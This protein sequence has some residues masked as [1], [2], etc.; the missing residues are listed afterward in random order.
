MRDKPG[1]FAF[2]VERLINTDQLKLMIRNL[3]LTLT[4]VLISTM[5]SYAQQEVFDC[6]DAE[7]AALCDLADVNGYTFTNPDPSMANPP[8]GGLC[9]GG[10]FNNPGWFSFVAGSTD[11][12][13][14][15][16]P[17]PMTCDT[18]PGGQTG[19][20]VAL[21]EG[22]PET[23]GECVAGDA[24]CSD[25][26]IT[27]TATGLTIG[28]IYN[29]VIDGCAGSVC[30]VQVFVDQSQPF[31]IP[32]IDEVELNEPEY[33]VRGGCDSALPDGN[34]CAGIKVLITVN[35]EIY[36]VLGAVYT[37]TFD[38]ISG[39]ADPSTV[40]WSS[41]PFS[42]VGSPAEIGDLSGDLGASVI[43]L[44]FTEPGVYEICLTEVDSECD[45]STGE[46]CVEVT[47]ITPGLQDF[48]QYDVCVLDLLAGWEVPD[49]DPNGNPWGAGEIDLQQVLDAPDGIVELTVQDDCGC[50]FTQ[51]VQITPVGSLDR[52]E[53]FLQLLP[54]QL[55]Y[56][57]FDITID[58][59]E[60]YIDGRDETLQEGSAQSDFEGDRCD[61][62]VTLFVIPLELQDSIIVGECTPQGTEFTITWTGLDN[63]GNELDLI[64]VTYMWIDSVTNMVVS[65]DETALL[66]S[67]TYYVS[68][69]GQLE[70]LNYSEIAGNNPDAICEELFGPYT[71][72]GGSGQ[73]P[74]V[75]PYDTSL[76]QDQLTN[77]VFVL[78]TVADTDYN[79]MVPPNIPFTISP[80]GDS[81]TVDWSGAMLTDTVKVSAA[82]DCG[83]S[84]PLSLPVEITQAN[85]PGVMAAAEDCISNEFNVEY[86]GD[87]SSILSFNWD[88]GSGVIT[89]GDPASG[90]PL[91]VAFPSAGS[92]TY[93]LTITDLGGCQASDMFDVT[94]EDPLEL[95]VITCDGD[96][97]QIIFSWTD[98]GV[99]SYTINETDV[100]PGATGTMTGPFE[101]TITGLNPND[102]ATIEIIAESSSPCGSV[103][104]EEIC[105]AS[106]CNLT[107]VNP[108][109]FPD[110]L[111]YCQNHPDNVVFDFEH[112][113]PMNITGLYSGNGIIDAAEGLFDPNDPSVVL[114]Q[115]EIVF[116]YMDSN[117]AAEAS[118]FIDIYE[119]PIADFSPSVLQACQDE[120]FT[121]DNFNNDPNAVWNYGSDFT[122]DFSGISYSSAGMQEI[123][124][125]VIDPITLCGDSITAQVEIL[126]NIIS[127]VITCTP[128][129]DFVNFDWLDIVGVSNYTVDVLV[130]GTSVQSGDQSN[131]DWMQAEL[132]EGDEVT[133]TVFVNADNGCGSFTEMLVCEAQTCQVPTIDLSSS[134]MTFCTNDNLN[135]IA[136]E[137]MVDGQ[138]AT[139]TF[140]GTGIADQDANEFNPSLAGPGMHTITF[141]YTSPFDNCITS[142]T[143]EFEVLDVPVPTF[144]VD[145]TEVCID[146]VATITSMPLPPNVNETWVFNT[147]DVT[148]TSPT[149]RIISFDSPGDYNISLNYTVPG[150]P[151]NE[152]IQ[153]I[154]VIDTITSP[155]LRCEDSGTDFIEFGW[156]D[157][158]NVD[159]YEVYIDGMF[160]GTQA[161]TSYMLTGLPSESM[162]EITLIAVDN[163]CGSRTVT[164]ICE[165]PSCVL[166]TFTTNVP[167]TQCYQPGSG[168]ILLDV[169]VA[170]NTGMQGSY[171]WDTPM[172]DGSNMFTPQAGD[173]DY[174]FNIIYTE[175][176][177]ETMELVEFSITEIPN[178]TLDLSVDDQ[179][180]CINSSIMVTAED[181][182]LTDEFEDWNFGDPSLVNSSGVGFGPYDLSFTQAGSYDISLVVENEGCF[183]TQEQVTIVVEDELVAPTINCTNQQVFS[184][185]FTWDAVDC[186]TDYVVFVDGT[187]VA[188]VQSTSYSLNNLAE[189][190]SVDVQVEAV[191]QCACENTMSQIESCSTSECPTT[192][193]SVSNFETNICLDVTANSFSITATPDDL[194]GNGTG[195]WSGDPFAS[196]NG[197]IDPSLV[198]AGTYQLSYDYEEGG[199]MYSYS[200]E[201]SFVGAPDINIIE[202]LDPSCIT[203][204]FG[205]ISVEG[206][207]GMSAYTYSLDQGAMQSSGEFG[208]VAPGAHTINVED[209]NG[210]I[211]STSVSIAPAPVVSLSI[212]GPVT[213]IL[214]NDATYTL[215]TDAPNIDNIIW[216]S[217]GNIVCEGANCLTY[218]IFSAL[219]D[220]DLSVQVIFNGDC[221][222]AADLF[223]NV[224]EIQAF[225]I[226]NM[227]SPTTSDSNSEWKMFI[228]GSETFVRS[229][230]VYNR[231]GNLVHTFDNTD[232]SVLRELIIWDG[233]IE[234]APAVT[235]VYVY[236]IEMEIES[237]PRMITGNVTVIR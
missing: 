237:I 69:T 41:G 149:E 231:W 235:E 150:C 120:V 167:T 183:S 223:V 34:F 133:V 163:E 144:A 61:S 146:D 112:E 4:F 148:T 186:A 91:G 53:V 8:G 114:G 32:E 21:W 147:T 179:V 93:F 85:T 193:F 2:F 131:S 98:V 204:N 7:E 236:L 172:V 141:S 153:T 115:N 229:V 102:E 5:I 212:D 206:V 154:T 230:K 188:T 166:P 60:D 80:N 57:W 48:G 30:T 184:L 198:S 66:N 97:S 185:D 205:Y 130:N 162:H 6:P 113:L 165:T 173:Q 105:A 152:A 195:A 52:E 46:L 83:E 108:T 47:I 194:T 170:S 202:E 222:V 203:D 27:L 207:G 132:A 51:T 82:N 157:Q 96:P 129:I 107:G 128:G 19:I 176:N 79:W 43:S 100:P 67:G 103:S 74:V 126:E 40:E 161:G 56:D 221:M 14:T 54:C 11:I 119:I 25:N 121:L 225:Y 214:E 71:L 215:V 9:G 39:A 94:I 70:D 164:L 219:Q 106:A 143:I 127:P 197:L 209:A 73:D 189:N 178:N 55:P 145:Q 50:E 29:L 233:Y 136:I 151:P 117:C 192:S 196:A 22:C 81:L 10:V 135:P 15:V 122:G 64:N 187:E 218:T 77:V 216:T 171:T 45:D 182:S 142:E 12:V 169:D 208:S 104:L 125:V 75:M 58:E 72:M 201:I 92:Y 84:D 158:T 190:Q 228:K 180:I 234:D 86:D 3:K 174:S 118:V 16:N 211:N 124:L 20:Q 213:V 28:E 123:K 155:T 139:G 210:C 26:P 62:L 168:A 35:D 42:G 1:L 59:M 220:A 99:D 101:Y 134:Q 24:N 200:T 37:W 76:C 175:G 160:I 116:T 65:T 111:E 226:P 49:E 44:V 109:N 140:Q 36:E 31:D 159:E 38:G 17:L 90:G 95:P 13:L 156:N 138:I 217:N 89:S 68:I 78:D 137:V 224:K 227:I 110:D 199:C 87:Q 23:S 191:S 33:N 88:F 181:A 232:L 18:T 63:D 177:C